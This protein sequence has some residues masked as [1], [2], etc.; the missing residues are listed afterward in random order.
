MVK[1]SSFWLSALL[2]VAL[3][4]PSGGVQSVS[5]LAPHEMTT[6]AWPQD[7][8]TVLS[9]ND[10]KQ[11]K[12]LFDLQRRLR[13]SQV[14]RGVSQLENKML[15]GHLQAVRLLHPLTKAKYSELKGWLA[16]HNDHGPAKSIYDL[17]NIRA[18]KG[19]KH[20]MP[21][22]MKP[23]VARYS[24]P[25]QKT[26][27]QVEQ[28]K[29]RSRVLRRLKYHRK[30]GQY[31][32]AQNLLM[33]KKTQ[34]LLGMETWGRVGLKLARTMLYK[35][36]FV[37]AAGVLA[38]RIDSQLV[39]KQPE[40]LWIAGFAAYKQGRVQDAVV[41][42]RKLAYAV[43]PTSKY[44]S[45]GA[46]WAA[47]CYE[48]LG[49]RAMTR[50]F[51]SM[52]ARNNTSFYG[53]MA[54]ERLGRMDYLKWRKPRPDQKVL[55]KLINDAGVRRVIALAQIG[56]YALAQQELKTIYP[57][58]PYEADDT[59]LALAM[60][61]NLS[62]AAMKLARNL[63][64]RNEVYLAGLYPL[65]ENWVPPGHVKVDPALVHA[66]IRQES[67][68]EPAAVSRVGARGLM[69]LMPATARFIQKKVG[70]KVVPRYQLFE[71]EINTKMGQ[72]YLI[73]LGDELG[74]NLLAILAGY[75]GGPGNVRKWLT[76]H[77]VDTT[78]PVLF[79]ESIPFKETRGYVMKVMANYWLYRH[80]FG[81]DNPTLASMARLHWP[82]KM[83][84][85]LPKKAR[86]SWEN[87]HNHRTR[88]GKPIRFDRGKLTAKKV[89]EKVAPVPTPQV[90]KKIN[91]LRG[92]IRLLEPPNVQ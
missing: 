83:I 92:E 52:A 84:A 77:D 4:L 47:H 48:K 50:V 86:K 5:R 68:F 28:T 12:K 55:S 65:L 20:A 39:L 66:I 51:M 75:N 59:L 40:A 42:F 79:V 87:G 56:E 85:A 72:N 78:N 43:P 13:R 45:R 80:Q 89:P 53:L 22:N 90:E 8:P 29:E 30:R 37:A 7:V 81:A 3:L 23:S 88:E 27:K 91:G 76:K 26:S 38:E 34:D 21:A 44:Y 1:T 57:S 32:R 69:Q 9:D 14:S 15:L 60:R 17:A 31:T 36:D 6:T 10:V 19:E 58:I 71:P 61:L 2:V 70:D 41:Y 35:D 64:E 24:A 16:K 62:G 54:T 11:Y 74:N 33:Q 18:P 25:E 67:A 73:H 49:K 82:E 46:W 63:K